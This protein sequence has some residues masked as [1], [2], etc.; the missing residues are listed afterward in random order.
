MPAAARRGSKAVVRQASLQSLRQA[1]MTGDVFELGSLADLDDLADSDSDDGVHESASKWAIPRSF[2]RRKGSS[3]SSPSPVAS[4][5]QHTG[6]CSDSVTRSI[7]QPRKP[8]RWEL[9]LGSSRASDDLDDDAYQAQLAALRA[10]DED[11]QREA[12]GLSKGDGR[13]ALLVEAP[14]KPCQPSPMARLTHAAASPPSRTDDAAKVAGLRQKAS[15]PP[16]AEYRTAAE[17]AS[18]AGACG[19][20]GGRARRGGST[21]SRSAQASTSTA[22]ARSY[23]NLG[24][25]STF[26]NLPREGEEP[27]GAR[28]KLPSSYSADMSSYDRLLHAAFCGDTLSCLCTLVGLRRFHTLGAVC[29]SWH[30]AILAKMRDWGMLTYV[31]SVGRGFGKLP[32]QYDMPTWVC[33][34]P[35]GHFGTNLCV[36]DSCNYR[37][38][39]IAPHDGSLLRTVG[40]PGARFG[41]LASPSSVAFDPKRPGRPVVYCS[42]NVGPEDRRIMAFDLETW[43]LIDATPEGSGKTELDAP[44]G[45]AVTEETIYVVD[46]AHHRIVAFDACTLEKKG[47]YPPASW[48]RTH[49][50]GKHRDQL[51]NPQ[52]IAAFEGELYVSD[53]HNDRIQV[54]NT[55]LVHLGTIGQKGRGPGQFNYP[56]GVT[57]ARSGTRA[58]A[59]LYV[60]EQTRIQA[61]TLLGE[62]RIITAIPGAGCLC[63]ICSDGVRV[64]VT[65]ME[66]HKVHILRLTHSEG[67]REQRREAIEEAKAR[68]ALR[69]GVGGSG[70]PS[71]GETGGSETGRERDRQVA[72][73]AAE[74]SEKEGRRDRAVKAVLGG[75]HV[76]A[77][78]GLP[79]TS[80]EAELM[81]AMRLA[82]RLLHPDAAINMAKKGTA[83]GKRIEAAFKRVNNLKDQRVEQWFSGD[84]MG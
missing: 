43:K 32:G 81:R 46:T 3:T 4:A 59:L 62:P 25:T 63:G 40:R 24:A 21:A 84:P 29:T 1:S 28:R 76:Y 2:F 17:E 70:A 77:M 52:D 55:A 14:S 45:M 9:V 60:A 75:R 53:T 39:I 5:E 51:D 68:N 56:R 34:V 58:P 71:G 19:S 74:R 79:S 31:R 42:C 78:L 20:T 48:Q 69:G 61:L 11:R 8:Q 18:A 64:Y 30:D 12:S 73:R 22:L 23:H 54:F 10:E 67:W 83:E 16:A 6:G 38:Q 15:T 33:I 47:Q 35:D 72:L 27:F 36:V 65:D 57:V 37:L 50:Q 80:S 7:P 41:E 13:V 26:T 66:T 44:E 49:G 82:M